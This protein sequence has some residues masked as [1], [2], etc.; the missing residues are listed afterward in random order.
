VTLPL[1]TLYVRALVRG[2][3]GR[4]STTRAGASVAAVG[5]MGDVYGR[6]EWFG[7]SNMGLQGRLRYMGL[8][9]LMF[10]VQG[11]VS[12]LSWVL[13]TKAAIAL[14]RQLGWGQL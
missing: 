1:D 3:L 14:G 6:G 2:F 9:A 8:M 11:C 7:G 13:V 5:L 10:G 4:P 12:S